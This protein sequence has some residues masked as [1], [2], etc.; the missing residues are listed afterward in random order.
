MTSGA[1]ETPT[2]A[3]L[4]RLYRTESYG[5]GSSKH[6]PELRAALAAIPDE[7][8]RKGALE[9]LHIMLVCA[10]VMKADPTNYQRALAKA[11]A[12]LEGFLRLH[13]VLKAP[14]ATSLA[15]CV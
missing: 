7:A 9:R 1:N 5:G 8:I 2:L 12:E 13:G 11:C 6:L 3:G 10:T 15:R 4:L 14:G